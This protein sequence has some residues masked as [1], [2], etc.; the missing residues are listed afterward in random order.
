MT[1]M[2]KLGSA[3]APP[4]STTHSKQRMAM[5]T[6]IESIK[7]PSQCRMLHSRW[8]VRI[9]RSMGTITVGPV[10]MTKLPVSRAKDGEVSKTKKTAVEAP[11]QVIRTPTVSRRLMT[12]EVCE[13]SFRSSVSP[14]SKRIK[15][16]AR[17]TIIGRFSPSALESMIP[18]P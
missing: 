7:T 6:P 4:P 18:R 12:V 13:N 11:I 17:D 2:M 10:T 15:P 8:W 14:P 16:I 9:R 3:T 5:N 1:R